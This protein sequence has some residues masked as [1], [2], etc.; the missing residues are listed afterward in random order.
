[1][2]EL[3]WGR[4]FALGRVREQYA[5]HPFPLFLFCLRAQS[6]A[7]F[8]FSL[9]LRGHPYHL[10]R[11]CSFHFTCIFSREMFIQTVVFREGFPTS[12]T[13]YR[14]CMSPVNVLPS[15]QLARTISCR[16]SKNPIVVE[17]VLDSVYSGPTNGA[18][19]IAKLMHGVTFIERTCK[20]LALSL[21]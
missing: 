14:R 5:I 13:L 19:F 7:R 10:Y 8:E 9:L 21:H 12:R 15:M 16:K 11:R 20:P 3:T 17:G 4:A 18:S 6:A 1:M 2:E